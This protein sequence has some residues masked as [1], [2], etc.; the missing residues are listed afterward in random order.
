MVILKTFSCAFHLDN[1]SSIRES[2]GRIESSVK[3]YQMLKSFYYQN[4][5]IVING[6]R[7]IISLC[8]EG[9]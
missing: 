8:A 7:Y 6:I 5:L 3:Q 4:I 2:I 1:V 9:V